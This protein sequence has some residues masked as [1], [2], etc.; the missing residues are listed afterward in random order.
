[1]ESLN[2]APHQAMENLLS[3]PIDMQELITL[4]MTEYVIGVSLVN[5]GGATRS[6]CGV[7]LPI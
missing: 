5:F 6:P 1:M 3:T 4:G 7:A 2:G